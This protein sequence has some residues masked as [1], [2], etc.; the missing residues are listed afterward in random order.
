MPKGYQQLTYEQRCQIYALKASG[1]SNR[2]IARQ[3]GVNSRTIDR[4][5][6]RNSGQRGYRF[7]QAEAKAQERRH[8][9][10]GRNVKMT[11]ELIALIEEKLTQCQWSPEQIAGWLEREHGRKIISHERIYQHIWADKKAGGT[12]YTHLRRRAK[13]YMKRVNGKTTRGQIIGRVDIEN[14]PS[15]VETR[16]RIGDWEADTI[17]GKAH[18]G[19]I[20]SLVERKT[21][22]TKLIKVERSTAD[23]VQLA[24]TTAL[25]AFVVHSITFDNGKEFALHLVIAAALNTQTFFAKPYH[26]WERGTNE[27]TNGLVRQ[28]VPKKT[29][30]ATVSHEQVAKIEHLLNTRPRKCLGYNTPERAYY[31]SLKLLSCGT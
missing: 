21:R 10:T 28:Y 3:I 24:I 23:A 7:K 13:K 1:N 19:A 16:E 15:V 9:K 25:L 18:Q 22:Y 17:V 26:S 11:P 20:V 8:R 30:F 12:L 29:D 6:A 27:N 14:R 2:K 5:V 4:E 31:Q